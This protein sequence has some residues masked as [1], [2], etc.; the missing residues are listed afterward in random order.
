MKRVFDES[1][2]ELMDVPQPVSPELE[3]DL[4]NL[5][6][7]NRWFGSHWLICRFLFAW[8]QPGTNYRILDLAT[9]SGDIPR[10]IANWCAKRGI[11]VQ[12]DAVDGSAATLEIARR[13][14]ARYANI[15][16]IQADALTY[17]S[18][19]TYDLVFCT[20]ALHHFSEEN[21]IKLL[22]RCRRLSHHYVLVSD[23]ERS[24][25]TYAGVWLLTALIYRDPMTQHDGRMSARRAFSWWE[26]RQMAQAAGWE[27]FGQERFLFCRQAIWLSERELGGIPV[28]AEPLPHVLPC[29]S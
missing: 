8:L 18:G 14:S 27:H 4:A 25:A 23:L 15:Q 20:L 29:P 6:S 10:L 19:Q 11:T 2:P 5:V 28:E 24:M 26:L 9:G 3:R 17:D 12:I 13:Q 16:W 21:A 7:L 22:Q 1:K